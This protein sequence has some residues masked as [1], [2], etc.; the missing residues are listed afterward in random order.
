LP[1]PEALASR[2]AKPATTVA[3]P[4]EAALRGLG[5]AL[6]NSSLPPNLVGAEHAFASFEAEMVAI[7]R[8]GLTH[9]LPAEIVER[10]FGLSF[11]LDQFCRNLAE[12]AGRIRELQAP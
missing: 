12:L 2:L 10:V 7:R 1:L 3:A 5:A 8:D 6:V 4:F 11:G 9:E